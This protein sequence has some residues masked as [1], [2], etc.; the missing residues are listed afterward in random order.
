MSEVPSGWGTEFRWG[1]DSDG[2][3]GRLWGGGCFV[4]G[5]VG[6][7]WVG[8]GV[9]VRCVARANRGSV[10]MIKGG[11]AKAVGGCSVVT[12]GRLALSKVS[13]M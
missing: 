4:G 8:G 6:G 10:A 13:G 1:M 3:G 7:G 11:D 9:A 12:L 5:G 2:G